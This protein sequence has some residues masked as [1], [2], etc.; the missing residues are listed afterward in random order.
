MVPCRSLEADPS[1]E[2]LSVCKMIAR[3]GPAIEVG[4][5]LQCLHPSQE[6]PFSHE[7]KKI[8]TARLRIIKTY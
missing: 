8:A 4:G 6:V 5:L 3:S 1:N 7:A 2:M